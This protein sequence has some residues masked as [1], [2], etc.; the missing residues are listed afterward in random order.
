MTK[1][2]KKIALGLLWLGFVSY[3]FLLSPPNQPDTFEL[4]KN[5]SIGNWAG[6]NPLIISLFNIMG[7]WPLVYACVLFADGRKQKIRAFPFIIASMFVGIFSVL[8]YLV[9]RESN[10][11]FVGPKDWLIKIFDARLTGIILLLA[12]LILLIF[13]FS[14]GD[15]QDFIQQWQTDRFIHTMSLDFCL[16]SLLFPILLQDDFERRDLG[17][18]SILRLVALFPLLGPLVYLCFRPHLPNEPA[19][20]ENAET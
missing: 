15:W 13:G 4:I 14:Q 6:I 18:S 8:P 5:L 2:I 12:T 7:V 3:A 10:P 11:H 17:N 1:N 20:A 19:I 9:L 16:L